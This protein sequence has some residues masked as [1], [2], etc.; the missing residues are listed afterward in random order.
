MAWS[1][2]LAFGCTHLPI[3]SEQF[4]Q[5][6]LEQI[7]E[8]NP[9]YV[10][11]LGDWIECK[12][13]SRWP[14]DH[15][16]DARREFHALKADAEDIRNAASKA[17]LVWVH[18]NHC[19]NWNQ[20]GRLPEDLRT[21]V[22]E[23]QELLLPE[24][25]SDWIHVPYGHDQFYRIGQVTFQHG[26]QT[27]VNAERDQSLL[28]G[29]PY[30][31][32]VSAHTHRPV[33]IT[34]VKVNQHHIFGMYYCNVGTGADWNQMHYMDRLNKE[35]WGRAIVKIEANDQPGKH[36]YAKRNWEAEFIRHSVKSE[37]F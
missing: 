4:R 26:C 19:D 23:Y 37:R 5:W 10:V 18:G 1:K 2:I 35:N 32:H 21:L 30:G 15:K 16:F 13:G 11:N 34:A 28:F 17:K 6:R 36:Y 31:L 24:V 12:F 22:G 29:V 14:S 33:D 7:R 8:Y 3:H 20:P 25:M 9:D 27:N